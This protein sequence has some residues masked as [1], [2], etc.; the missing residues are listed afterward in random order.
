MLRT[1]SDKVEELVKRPWSRVLVPDEGVIAASVPE[2]PGCFAEGGTLEEALANL[3][4][5][6]ASWLSAAI[7]SELEI[8]QPKG[9]IEE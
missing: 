2:L 6:L 4:D 9:E 5:A 8:P 7:E 1:N 3:E